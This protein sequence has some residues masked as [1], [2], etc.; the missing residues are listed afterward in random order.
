VLGKTPKVFNSGH[1]DRAFYETFWQQ[2]T[3][4]GSWQGEIWN[5]RKNGTVFPEWLTITALRDDAGE[6]S[7]FVAVFSDIS[8]AKASDERT[9]Y[10]AHHDPLTGL[11]NRA[12]FVDRLEQALA[13][14]RRLHTTLAVAIADIDGFKKI[15]DQLGHAKGDQTLQVVGQRMREV[16]RENDTLARVGG[17]EFAL[18]FEGFQS[19]S[20]IESLGARLVA[21]GALELMIDGKPHGVTVSMG[22]AFCSDTSDKKEALLEAADA[23]MY[24]AKR[25]GK[26]RFVVGGDRESQPAI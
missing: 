22:I 17:D 6:I 8:L 5:R 13:R 7:H 21:A 2:L 10:L 1:H 15:N 16:L 3:A 18:V 20:D 9:L 26:N 25:A 11:P 12:L 23:A 24:T 4:R 14:H 19:R